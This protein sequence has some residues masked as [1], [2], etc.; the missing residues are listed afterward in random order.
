MV[1]PWG[2]AAYMMYSVALLWLTAIGFVVAA[3][4]WTFLG[5]G[6]HTKAL[7]RKLSSKALHS[8]TGVRETMGKV[9]DDISGSWKELGSTMKG[10]LR[11]RIL[12]RFVRN[13][14]SIERLMRL[15]AGHALPAQDNGQHDRIVT[16][17]QIVPPELPNLIEYSSADSV[18]QAT[19]SSHSSR[20][21]SLF[22]DWLFSMGLSPGVLGRM[23]SIF[24]WM[25]LPFIGQWLF[26][27]GFVDL[28][29]DT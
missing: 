27:V 21:N 25:A 3:A 19:V 10:R 7:V 5:F 18:S 26:W 1:I 13:L 17:N 2:K 24:A 23:L 8:G 14:P 11:Q 12:L 9:V 28:A 6:R 29:G 15:I 4:I 22:H 16:Q 20:A